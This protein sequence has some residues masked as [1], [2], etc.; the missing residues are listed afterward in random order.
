MLFKKKT[1]NSNNFLLNVSIYMEYAK[2]LEYSSDYDIKRKEYLLSLNIE[3]YTHNQIEELKKFNEEK[4]YF[5]KFNRY[6]ENAK[7]LI[8]E[9]LVLIK[10]YIKNNKLDDIYKRKLT[11]KEFISCEK[12]IKQIVNNYTNEQI[13][14][15]LLSYNTFDINN[16]KNMSITDA[17]IFH[18]LKEKYLQNLNNQKTKKLSIFSNKYVK[19]AN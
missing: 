16:Y 4:S 6:I 19:I 15:V 12:K 18:K 1:E 17:Y 8:K 10:D 5:K 2:I 3:E 14:D 11:K 7:D 9:D 13:L